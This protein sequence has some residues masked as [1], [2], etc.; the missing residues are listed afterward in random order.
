MET[1]QPD[2]QASINQVYQN[3]ANML[4]H[5]KLDEVSV[6]QSLV[7]QGL[8]NESAVTVVDNL[9]TQ[10]KA[11]KKA[12]AHKDILY[13]ALWC[14][15]GIVLTVAHIGFIFWGAIIFGGFQF[16]KGLANL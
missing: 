7:N 15:G 13:G 3:A 5:Q 12:R 16:F 14:V 4:I 6:I 10:I 1:I 8:D 2:Q 9:Q 11:A